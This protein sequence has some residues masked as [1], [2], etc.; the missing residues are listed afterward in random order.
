MVIF[1]PTAVLL[2]CLP[3]PP[4]AVQFQ[5]LFPP[6]KVVYPGYIVQHAVIAD[7]VRRRY[8]RS[9]IDL[10]QDFFLVI[11]RRR[12]EYLFAGQVTKV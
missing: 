9:V 4:C 8:I 5:V 11:D 12:R 3:R 7:N 6:F 10:E 1:L 2:Q